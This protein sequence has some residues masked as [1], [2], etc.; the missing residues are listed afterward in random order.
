MMVDLEADYPGYGFARHKGYGTPQH[1][2]A[3]REL[4]ASPIHRQSFAPLCL[5]V[6][7]DLTASAQK[8]GGAVPPFRPQSTN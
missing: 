7:R 3:L 5:L 6:A 8:K 1:Q 2:A 4:G